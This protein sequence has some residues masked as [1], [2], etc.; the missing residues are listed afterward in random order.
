MK[1]GDEVTTCFTTPHW[2]RI[3][4]VDKGFVCFKNGGGADKDLIIAYRNERGTVYVRTGVG[5]QYD[6]GY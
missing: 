4:K 2:H 3:K 1:I 6:I 5:W